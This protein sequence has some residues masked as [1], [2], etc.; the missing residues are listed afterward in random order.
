MLTF[1]LMGCI[2]PITTLRKHAIKSVFVEL[3]WFLKGRTDL[4]YLHDENVHIWDANCEAPNIKT[5][6]IPSG[7]VGAIYGHQWR[8]FGANW[9]PNDDNQL[10]QMGSEY[11]E[12]KGF[13][14]INY[15]INELKTNPFSRRILLSG[16]NPPSIFNNAVLPPCHVSYTFNVKPNPCNANE[17]RLYCLIHQRSS[18]VGLALFWNILSGT[19]LTYL[20][21]KTTNLIPWEISIVI[22]N[23][24]IYE[25]HVEAVKEM[26]LRPMYSFPRLNI[27]TQK[28][29]E[30]YEFSDLEIINYTYNKSITIG[31]MAV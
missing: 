5:M 1:P 23:A 12:Q 20:I 11:S 15:I 6:N 3:M 14:Q 4:Q 9:T 26:I 17:L 7:H 29:I 8:R 30:D 27:T 25:N 10:K 2:L 19:L 18:D 13:D 22:A 24:H 31:A 21:A 28:N 16:W